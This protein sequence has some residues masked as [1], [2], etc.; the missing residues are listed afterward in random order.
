MP[1]TPVRCL[2]LES[3]PLLGQFRVQVFKRHGTAHELQELLLGEANSRL[4]VEDAQKRL[5]VP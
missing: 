2:P 4:M 3:R 5:D 1:H